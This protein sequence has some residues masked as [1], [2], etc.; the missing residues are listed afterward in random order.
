MM[1]IKK[2]L[3]YATVIDRQGDCGV[4]DT[5]DDA[6][7]LACVAAEEYSNLDTN[8]RNDITNAAISTLNNHLEELSTMFCKEIGQ[9]SYDEI[10][11][12]NIAALNNYKNYSILSTNN[13][14][15]AYNDSCLVSGIIV[16]SSNSLETIIQNSILTLKAGNAIVFSSNKNMKNVF[17]YAIKLINNAIE[18]IGGPKNLVVT[19]K[20]PS[21]ESTN[22]LIENEKVTL[23]SAINSCNAEKVAL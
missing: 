7:R 1:I 10:L 15:N 6:I 19:V 13:K 12:D 9:D 22:I 11:H 18:A 4:F 5:M 3:Q 21:N 2:P 16:E 20:E 8:K 14:L 17:S 23:I